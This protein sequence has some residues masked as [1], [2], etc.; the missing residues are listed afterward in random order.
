M[1]KIFIFLL[2]V[3]FLKISFSQVT[4]TVNPTIAQIQQRLQ[5]NGVIIS[6]V[7][8]T[9]PTGAYALYGNGTGALSALPSGILLTTG[10]ATGINSSNGT[11]N[12][13]NYNAPGSTLGDDLDLS[14]SGT[15]DECSVRFII[16]PNCST[17]SIKYVFASEEY[18]ENVGGGVSDVFGFVIDGP[19]PAGGNY[20]QKN[21]ALVPGT[22]L[23]VS[24]DNV[25]YDPGF[26]PIIPATCN[27]CA[28]YVTNPPGMVYDGSTTVLSASTSVTPCQQYTMTI[29]VWD[30]GD[31]IYDSGVFL[32]VQGLACIGNPTLTA[33]P[34]PS[35]I[36]GAQTITLTAGGAYAGG[37]YTWTAPASGGLV[38]NTGTVVTANP[39]G[40][41]TYTLLYSDANTC[42]G[43]PLTKT[44]TVTFTAP[45]ALPVTQN[46]AG[47]ICAGQSVTLTANGGTGTYSW[48][49]GTSLTITNS[50]VTIASPSVTTTYSVTKN[51]SGCISNTVIT[52]SV[53]STSV[54]VTPSLTTICVGQSSTLTSSGAGP[55]VWTASTGTNPP[56]TGTVTVTPSVTTNYTVVSGAGTCTASAVATVSIS[57]TPSINITPSVSTICSGQSQALSSSGSGPFSWTASSGATPPSAANVTVTPGSTTTYTVLSGT[58]TC[59]ATAVATVSVGTPPVINITPASTTICSG[60]SVNLSS[61]GPGPFTWTASSGSN[62]TNSASVTVTPSTTTTYT[63]ISGTG[64]CTSSAVST[65]SVSPSQSIS[66]TPSATII[67]NGENVTLSSN[68]SAPFIWTASNGANPASTG[69]VIVTPTTTTTYTVLSGTGACTAQAVATVSIA[70]ALS[71]NITPSNTTICLGASTTLSSTGSGPFSWTASTGSNPPGTSTV[72]VTPS[73]TTTY[74]V[75]SGTGACTAQATATVSVSPTLSINITPSNT[76]ICLGDNVVLTST[77]SG[78]FNWMASSGT[79]PANSQTVTV[80]PGTTT[81]Y[82]VISGTGA[83]TA[84]AVATVSITPGLSITV[85]PATTVICKGQSTSLTVNGST[86]PFIWTASTGVSPSPSGTVTVTPT[87][88]TTYTVLAGTGACTAVAVATVSISP[89]LTLN[90]TPVNASVCIG[91]GTTLTANG[92][93]SYTW[94]PGFGTGSTL[95]VTPNSTSS[96]TVVGTD[97]ICVNTATTQVAVITLTANATS[98]STYYCFGVSPVSLTGT[99]ATNYTWSPAS[100]LSSSVGA[101]VTATPSATTIYTLTGSTSGC[102][103]T[104]TISL[105]VPPVSS[106]SATMSHS[107]VCVG[108]T[109]STLT[110]NGANTYTWSA[111]SVTTPTIFVNP[112]TTSS[113]T[114]VGQTAQGCYEVPAVITVSVLPTI[115]PALTASSPTVCLTKTVSISAPASTGLTYT[116]QPATAISGA[117]NTSSIV[118]MPPTVSPVIYTVTISNGV[119]IGTNTIQ[120]LVRTPPKGNF[121]TLNNDTICTGGCVTFSSTTTGSSPITY[122]WYYQ[123]GIGTSSVGVAPEACYPS[124][125]SFSV[126]MVATN[127]CGID[128]IIKNNYIK[129]YDYPALV[130]GGDT[131]I[132][133]GE[134]AEIFASGGTNYSWSPNINGSIVCSSCSSTIVQPTLTTQY[135]VVASNSIYCRVRDTVTITVDVNCGDFFIPNV[136]SPNG[137]GLNDM[138]NVHGRC[139]STFNLQIFNRWGEKVFET[140]SLSE[141]WD[142]TFRGQKMDTGVFIYK[143]DGVSIDGQSFNM[144]GNITLM[145]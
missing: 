124:A 30:V 145:R 96:Y 139:I 144:K 105:T 93:T 136:F 40:T 86:G 16:T 110:A 3:L 31:G 121:I 55:F 6:S 133:I 131:T 32:D 126:T 15:F 70:P 127:A 9:C 117:N 83:C 7:S 101:V 50:S 87:T 66:I 107:V 108:G 97:G 29:G 138:I 59:T 11:Q 10:K 12:S 99:G 61:S 68:G 20:N 109:G 118:A 91:S 85:T 58:G 98:N 47:V 128:S 132:N 141:S 95:S 63:V 14:G 1:K 78:P 34:S 41:T 36:C 28:Y 8:L 56:G 137:D 52:V 114:V 102:I 17:L 112:T 57:T 48:T 82:T 104:H 49:P 25:N 60:I 125:G 74:T 129:V 77:G 80:S 18:P 44:T 81:S 120:L 62:P 5:G 143:A 54:S 115:N 116:W 122:K 42:P 45:P 84:Q 22:N 76:I 106:V 73:A 100:S 23:P 69:T 33:T 75:M 103:S 13:Q 19:N 79:N 111:G 88:T 113:Y 38:T 53:T 64:T 130:V 90:I 65:V 21:I 43:V 135:I 37:T 51:M 94:I 92:A 4:T 24:I 89:S 140:S 39:T 27:N 67:C 26:P 2:S 72:A 46:P 71:I 142:G 123:V 134:S 35:T 119:C